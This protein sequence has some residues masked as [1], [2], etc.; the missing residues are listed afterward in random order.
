LEHFLFFFFILK[1]PHSLVEDENPFLYGEQTFPAFK[2]AFFRDNTK[3]IKMI[4]DERKQAL[5]SLHPRRFGKS[6]FLS[7]FNEYYDL[8][9]KDR[10]G[11]LF[12]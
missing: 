4:E 8:K 2:G 6:L 7:T 3:F 10:L 9:N 11:E 1:N 12:G 5:I